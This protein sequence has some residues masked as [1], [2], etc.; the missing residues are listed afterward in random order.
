MCLGG[1]AAGVTVVFRCEK[2][3][4]KYIPELPID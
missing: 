4:T 2:Y 1:T 3:I